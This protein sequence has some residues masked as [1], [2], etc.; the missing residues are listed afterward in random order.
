MAPTYKK[1]I[2][3]L[4]STTALFTFAGC[5]VG[6]DYQPPEPNMPQ[7][8]Y[9]DAENISTRNTDIDQWWTNFNDQTLNRLIEQAALGNYDLQTAFFRIQESRSLRNFAIGEY[10]PVVDGIGSY[11][12][13][14]PSANGLSFLQNGEPDQFN[15]SAL[16]FDAAWEIDL[17]GRIKRNVQS[18]TARFQASIENFH[19]VMVSL[20]A[21][22]ALNYF[23]LRTAQ[24][25]IEYA[26]ENIES[27]R[28]TLE[29]TKNRFAADLAPEL[30]VRQA[31]LN[32]ANTESEIPSLK[33]QQRQ[34]LN[35][36]AVLLGKMPI[37]LNKDLR[38]YKPIPQVNQSI[39][40]GI[41][42]ELLRRRPD[43]RQA[44]RL[45]AS[46]T[47]LIGAA[48][49]EQYPIFSLFG[50]FELQATNPSDLGKISS[51]AY[52]FGPSFTWR[53]FDASRL[54]NL[55]DVQKAQTAAQLAQYKN[56]VL[57]AVEEV[58][59]S[60]IAYTLEIQRKQSLQDSV[61]AA[62]RSVELVEVL[63][64]SGLTDFQNVLDTQRTLFNQQDRL[65]ISQGL[66]SQDLTRLY[67]ALGGGWPHDELIANQS[68]NKKPVNK[69][70]RQ[71]N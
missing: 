5:A 8:W 34:A 45:L 11:T 7:A 49:A 16:G 39:A 14:R 28:Q 36:L 38:K 42:A 62:K 15:L 23:E 24:Q 63:Y 4:I 17:F 44:E 37:T 9:E 54:E 1:I 60:M 43:I 48:K 59:N 56:I 18:S 67:K 27:Q 71:N 69:A 20:F 30:D 10:Y 61:T 53:L 52:S 29:L 22:V 70:E 55:V 66:I 68:V 12:R 32:L 35:R 26:L 41:P 50:T 65:A 33:I 2:L 31:E 40:A 47:Y 19:N 3:P 21:E 46:Q 25:R 64:K 51:R 57:Q 6:P 13:T 58:E